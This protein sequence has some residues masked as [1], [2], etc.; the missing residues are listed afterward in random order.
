[1]PPLVARGMVEL[2]VVALREVRGG[3]EAA[4]H[5]DVD[6]RQ[7][8]LDQQQPRPLQP[9]FEIILRRRTA[10]ML[11][12]QAL[13]LAARQADGLRQF[14]RWQRILQILL[15]PIDRGDKLRMVAADP[16]AQR[17]ALDD[18]GG[19]NM[20]DQALFGNLERQL[21][22][23]LQGNQMHHHIERRRP[24]GTGK[25]VA[26]DLVQMG[27]DLDIGKF[28]GESRQVLPMDRAF[29]AAVQPRVGKDVGSG[30][31]RPDIDAAPVDTMQKR[32]QLKITVKITVT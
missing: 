6:D 31:N 28:L 18:V 11:A 26:V 24:A 17:H 5:R 30:T 19:P 10:N 8:G 12:K 16:G 13:E 32:E 22:A 2:L 25:A 27:A 3:D 21:L 4:R 7:V 29:M 14:I 9:Q 1:M 15:H 23:V 20:V